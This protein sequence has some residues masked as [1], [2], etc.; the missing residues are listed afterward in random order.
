MA[1]RAMDPLFT[2]EPTHIVEQGAKTT[3]CGIKM[4]S[5]D[6]FPY[7]GAEHA[8]AHVENGMVVCTDC[9]DGCSPR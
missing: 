1:E 8:P 9:E 2:R 5:P 7:V 3:R 6:R 4:N